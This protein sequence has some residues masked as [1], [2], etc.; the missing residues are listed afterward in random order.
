[1]KDYQRAIEYRTNT[2]EMNGSAIE[3]FGRGCCYYRVGK[4]SEALEDFTAAI[5][6][7]P[8]Q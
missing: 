1:M 2:I 5:E 8:M 6:I 3:Y 4:Y 7:D